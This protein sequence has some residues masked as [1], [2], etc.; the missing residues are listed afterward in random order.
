MYGSRRFPGGRFPGRGFPGRF[1]PPSVFPPVTI[2]ARVVPAY[3][4]SRPTI[5]RPV[6]KK[7]HLINIHFITH[8]NTACFCFSFKLNVIVSYILPI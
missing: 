1:I 5:S 7:Q 2:P 8:I 3:A 6:G 4:N